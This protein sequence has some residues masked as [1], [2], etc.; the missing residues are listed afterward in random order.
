MFLAAAK[1]GGG[2]D[3]ELKRDGIEKGGGGGQSEGMTDA[4]W[5][6]LFPPFIGA[7]ERKSA[8]VG[9]RK[10]TAWDRRRERGDYGKGKADSA[11][12]GADGSK[13]PVFP[14]AWFY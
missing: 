13:T 2:K 8:L 1:R 7:E 11:E 5:L 9:R 10:A 4:L 6:P 12:M 14:P 3:S